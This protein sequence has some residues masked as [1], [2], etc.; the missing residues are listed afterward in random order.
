MV[1]LL[2]VVTSGTVGVVRGS[3][4]CSSCTSFTGTMY[5][6]FRNV[7]ESS[8]YLLS[9]LVRNLGAFSQTSHVP[10][11]CSGFIVS[12]DRAFRGHKRDRKKM[13]S[14]WIMTTC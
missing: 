6:G 14:E 12:E 13:F 9:F 2:F 3:L 4:T 7:E 8:S 5:S 1:A 11:D 10:L